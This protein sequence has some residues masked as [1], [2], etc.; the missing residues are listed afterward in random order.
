MTNKEINRI[1]GRL[2][3]GLLPPSWAL[4]SQEDQEDYG[5]DGEIE[6]TTPEDKATGLIF[7]MQLKGTE[8]ATYDEAGQL[9]YSDASVERFTYYVKRVKLPVIFVVCDV[10][11]NQCFWTRVQGEPEVETALKI[12]AEKKQGTFTV[13]LGPARLFEKTEAC[14]ARVIEAVGAASDTIALRSVKELSAEVVSN[15]LAGDPDAAAAEKKFRLFAGIASLEALSALIRSGDL[16][17]AL[18]KAEALLQ[19]SAET[20]MLRIQAG[21]LFAHAYGIKVRRANA[22]NAHLDAAKFR[23][24]VSGTLLRIARLPECDARMRL[25]VRAYARASRMVVNARLMFAIALSE[26]VQRLQGETL[27]GPLT[28]IERINFTNRV[29]RDFRRLHAILGQ[30]L[31]R[32]LYSL[33]PYLVEDWLETAM[34]FVQALR[35]AGQKESAIAF[36]D[37][38][39]MGVHLAVEL[40]K[41]VF[42]PAGAQQILQAIGLKVTGLAA[43]DPAEAE[44]LIDRY[45]QELKAAPPLPG[46]AEIIGTMRTLLAEAVQEAKQKPTLAE[47]RT[48]IEEQAAALGIDLSDP[49]DQMAEVVR[50]GLEDLDPTR[51]AYRCRHIHLRHG[52][53]GLPAEM[54]GLP[55]AGF[56]SVHCLKHGHSMEGLKLDAVYDLFSRTMP[57]DK[58]GVKCDMCPD[59]SPHPAGWAWSEEWGA[60]QEAL[61]AKLRAARTKKGK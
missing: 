42:G 13:K 55:T 1:S 27:G 22:T 26:K 39:W 52:P 53:R 20:P 4:R 46:G 57:W 24:G 16:D 25:Y 43:N 50:I 44:K 9:V 6:V 58:K 35:L 51:V 14:A 10:V 47:L 7:K 2:F 34:P 28:T 15:H 18:K 48:H 5:I 8:H 40:A 32:K 31:D 30:A 56:K 41:A 23:L 61:F 19:N 38:L 60:E 17:G 49:D 3:E 29:T 12:A 11:K 33:A 36:Q 45:E 37:V 59:V 21:V 54:L